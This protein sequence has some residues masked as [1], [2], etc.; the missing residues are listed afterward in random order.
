MCVCVA[1][2]AANSGWDESVHISSSPHSEG[3]NKNH[4]RLLYTV[5]CLEILDLRIHQVRYSIYW[6]SLASSLLGV[7]DMSLE[8]GS[9]RKKTAAFKFN[10]AF[11][12]FDKS[13]D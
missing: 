9:G 7:G 11:F 12:L 13:K 1:E 5:Q 10:A 8:M 4:G 3:N 6:L 2:P